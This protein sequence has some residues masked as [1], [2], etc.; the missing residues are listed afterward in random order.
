MQRL[1]VVITPLATSANGFSRVRSGSGAATARRRSSRTLF[2]SMP[3]TDMNIRTIRPTDYSTLLDI[4]ERSVR[5]T[6]GFLTD[7]DIDDLRPD[8]DVA[9]RSEAIGWW[10]LTS[11]NEGVI[12]FLGFVDPA[13][14]A[15][16]IDPK[17]HRH[18]AGRRLV[19]HAQSLATQPLTVDVNEQNPEAVQFYAALGFRIVGR[20]P[21]DSAG[22]P[23]PLLHM[24]RSEPAASEAV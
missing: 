20:S 24:R 15:L 22:R 8:V 14:E 19:A 7:A 3:A 17:H 11:A 23:F 10:I 13:I 16:F 6:H 4:W 18:G 5:A 12:G 21:T 1:A 9:L 2:G